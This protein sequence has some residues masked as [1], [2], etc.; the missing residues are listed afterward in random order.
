MVNIYIFQIV[1]TVSLEIDGGC[2]IKA[3]EI[4]NAY[5]Y[6]VTEFIVPFKHLNFRYTQ[7]IPVDYYCYTMKQNTTLHCLIVTDRDNVTS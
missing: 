6:Y 5:Y 3:V 4:S 7:K 2:A 1:W